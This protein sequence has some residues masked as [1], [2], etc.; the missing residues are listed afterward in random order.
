MPKYL[1][2]VPKYLTDVDSANANREMPTIQ[3]T[4]V[5]RIKLARCLYLSAKY[6]TTSATTYG[7]ISIDPNV[8][9]GLGS[10]LTATP[11]GAALCSKG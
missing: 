2:N 1:A 11:L 8:F 10:T 4:T 9:Q 5:S 7:I 3:M 6:A